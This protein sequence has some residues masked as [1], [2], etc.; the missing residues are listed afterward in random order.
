MWVHTHIRTHQANNTL[1]ENQNEQIATYEKKIK[2]RRKWM[3]KKNE[4]EKSDQ[5]FFCVETF[6]KIV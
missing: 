4:M 1:T 3:N 5:L 6:F 2:E